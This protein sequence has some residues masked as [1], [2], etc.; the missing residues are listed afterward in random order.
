MVLGL[1]R[2]K[3]GEASIVFAKLGYGAACCHLNIWPLVLKGKQ[4][5]PASYSKKNIKRL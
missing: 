5:L 1:G 4:K 2:G 3:L